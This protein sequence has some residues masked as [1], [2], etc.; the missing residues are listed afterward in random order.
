VTSLLFTGILSPAG[1]ICLER[2]YLLCLN[3]F[4]FRSKVNL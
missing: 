1:D 3:Y 2:I 4:G